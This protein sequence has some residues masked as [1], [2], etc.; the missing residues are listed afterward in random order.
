[1]NLPW[2]GPSR[3]EIENLASDLIERY[4]DD[5]YDEALLISD[6]WRTLGAH[7]NEKKHRL[8]AVRIQLR[9]EP[10]PARRRPDEARAP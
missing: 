9:A 6:A 2:F 5:A 8:A 10:T 7:M 4:G 1:M 3:E